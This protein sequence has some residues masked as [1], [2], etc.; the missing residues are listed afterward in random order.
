MSDIERRIRRL[1]DRAEL[2]DLV[3]R[4][5]LASDDDDY[6]S[7]LKIFAPDMEFLISN[8][9]CGVGREAVMAF[10]KGERE[11]MGSTIHT[12]HYALLTFESEDRATGLVGAH[13]EL[14]RAGSTLFG[15]VRYKD[16]YVRQG[17][18]WQ[19]RRKNMLV[20]HVAPWEKVATSMTSERPVIWPGLDPLPS[21]FPRKKPLS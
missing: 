10:L 9:S 21:D 2:N 19:I 6:E 1:E 5:F 20:V 11:K 7:Y 18:R 3:V 8:T 15:A 12:P 14:A 4:Y 16:E 17:G 13:L